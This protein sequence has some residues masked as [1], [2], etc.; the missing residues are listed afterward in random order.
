M[1]LQGHFKNV[2]IR[3][4]NELGKPKIA[5]STSK[6]GMGS[7]L[8]GTTLVFPLINLTS[9]LPSFMKR[10]LLLQMNFLR[11]R[12]IP[13][14]FSTTE[15]VVKCGCGIVTFCTVFLYLCWCFLNW[16][17]QSVFLLQHISQCSWRLSSYLI[18][19]WP[20]EGF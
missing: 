9:I 2:R 8:Y 12:Q 4:L 16:L 6:R 19:I 7:G 1:H 5:T 11:H 15:S 18:S 20:M 13:I 14:W 17:F 3:L 10:Q